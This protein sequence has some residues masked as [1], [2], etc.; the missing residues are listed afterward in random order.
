[1]ILFGAARPS[2]V[3][4]PL[5]GKACVFIRSPLM[6]SIGKQARVA[7]VAALFAAAMTA[8]A[9]RRPSMIRH[10]TDNIGSSSGNLTKRLRCA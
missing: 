6:L 2:N 7:I 3:V 8:R 5:Q 4:M 9:F 1:M 10:A